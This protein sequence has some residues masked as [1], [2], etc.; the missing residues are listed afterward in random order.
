MW[1]QVP[2]A[3]ESEDSMPELFDV[4]PAHCE[5]RRASG[6]VGEVGRP[7][8]AVDVAAAVDEE[9]V[10]GDVAAVVAGEEQRDR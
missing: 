3:A 4:E 6:L 1:R 2:C 7:R 8:R 5:G 10:P 9:R